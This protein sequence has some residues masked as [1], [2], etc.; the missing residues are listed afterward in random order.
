M[1]R[2]LKCDQKKGPCILF[3]VKPLE[4]WSAVGMSCTSVE[5]RGCWQKE[6]FR[7]RGYFAH[8]SLNWG[9]SMTKDRWACA[10][11]YSYTTCFKE[12]AVIHGFIWENANPFSKNSNTIISSFLCSGKS[13]L[14]LSMTKGQI[15]CI[16]F[17]V[18]LALKHLLYPSLS[19]H[20]TPIR[21]TNIAYVKQSHRPSGTYQSPCPHG[22]RDVGLGK[23]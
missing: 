1:Q 6:I 5:G 2:S 8:V 3:L 21:L 18:P 13:I 14:P 23:K 17:D 11:D 9:F 15:R 22:L 19:L 7:R 16:F 20:P 10:N 4:L 12:L